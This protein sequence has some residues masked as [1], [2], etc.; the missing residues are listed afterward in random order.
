MKKIVYLALVVLLAGNVMAQFDPGDFD[1]D[2][3]Y[4]L[5]ALGT[6]FGN[7]STADAIGMGKASVT[8][9][10]GIADATSVFGV[11]TYGL[12]E[13]FDGRAKLGIV[14]N[15]D[16]EISFGADAKYQLWS[17]DDVDPK[18]V[19]GAVGALF[20][21]WGRGGASILQFGGMVL[22][23]YPITLESGQVLTPYGRFNTRLER[24][25]VDNGGSE[26]NVRFGLNAG[27]AFDLNENISLLGEFQ[28]DGND[29]LFLGVEYNIM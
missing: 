16:T 26:S 20:E 10:V 6:A 8:G 4:D 25:S 18:P 17:V 1:I 27:V 13:Y 14:S 24:W 15:G 22:A 9:G 21:Y 3:D 28:L 19:D 12:S 23:S 11:L 2:V 5:P 7:L 29:G